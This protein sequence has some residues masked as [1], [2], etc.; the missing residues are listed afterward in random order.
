[1]ENSDYVLRKRTI[2]DTTNF[3]SINIKISGVS[4]YKL[5]VPYHQSWCYCRSKNIG[6]VLFNVAVSTNRKTWSR[7]VKT[8]GIHKLKIVIAYHLNQWYRRSKN[9]GPVPFKLV[10]SANEKQWFCTIKISGIF[11]LKVMI[12]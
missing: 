11:N 1:M 10:V 6:T 7:T 3:N 2:R 4:N 8:C 9:N 5:M 12:L